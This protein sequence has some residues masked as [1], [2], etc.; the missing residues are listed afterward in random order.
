MMVGVGF[1]IGQSYDSNVVLQEIIIVPYN[2]ISGFITIDTANI[3]PY[4][5][6]CSSDVAKT[7]L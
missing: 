6:N 4:F 5:R 2:E 3:E 7:N 1:I